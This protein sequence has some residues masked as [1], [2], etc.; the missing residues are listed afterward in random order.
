MTWDMNQVLKTYAAATTAL[1][2]MNPGLVLAAIAVGDALL[3]SPTYATRYALP[4]LT[5]PLKT[6]TATHGPPGCCLKLHVGC[7]DADQRAE[8]YKV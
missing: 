4:V 2:A 5:W 1:R 3:A 7:C 8:M 6:Q